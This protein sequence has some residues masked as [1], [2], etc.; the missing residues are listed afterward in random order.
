MELLHDTCLNRLTAA[1]G[2]LNY[3][4]ILQV[5]LCVYEDVQYLCG[6]KLEIYLRQLQHMLSKPRCLEGVLREW[7]VHRTCSEG[8]TLS[9]VGM[10]QPSGFVA[11]K[12]PNG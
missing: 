4:K 5:G 10:V 9:R 3:D 7:N 6:T 11:S 8:A 12:M 1:L 2:P